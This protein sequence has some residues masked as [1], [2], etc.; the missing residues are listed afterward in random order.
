MDE[1]LERGSHIQFF[2]LFGCGIARLVRVDFDSHRQVAVLPVDLLVMW[3]NF[4]FEAIPQD[5]S[6]PFERRVF[7][8]ARRN[9]YSFELIHDLWHY[10]YVVAIESRHRQRRAAQDYLSIVSHCR[11]L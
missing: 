9:H 6:N 4:V 8:K 1:R 2:Q 7:K 11:L 3:L 5:Q 10:L